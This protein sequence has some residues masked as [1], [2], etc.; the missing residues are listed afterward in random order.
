M[1]V[2]QTEACKYEIMVWA[3]RERVV[4]ILSDPFIFAGISGHMEIVKVFDSVAQDFV[5][6]LEAKSP[7]ARFKVAYI[8]DVKDGKTSTAVGEMTG[9]FFT[10]EGSPTAVLPMTGSSTGA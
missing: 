8:F 10:P 6:P 9:P 2:I 3:F 5:E 4:E 1:L 7:T